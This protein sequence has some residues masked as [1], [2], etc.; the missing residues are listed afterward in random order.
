MSNTIRTAL[1]GGGSINISI[2]ADAKGDFQLEAVESWERL[3]GIQSASVS[4]AELAAASDPD[5]LLREKLAELVGKHINWKAA[6]P[7]YPDSTGEVMPWEH[8]TNWSSFGE[9]GCDEKG[10]GQF[11]KSPQYCYCYCRPIPVLNIPQAEDE[12]Q[13][14]TASRLVGKIQEGLRVVLC[15]LDW[16]PGKTCGI[17]A[18]VEGETA[19]FAALRTCNRLLSFEQLVKSED[20]GALVLEAVETL[21]N[22][23]GSPLSGR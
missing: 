5:A 11:D 20:P 23:V 14:S 19:A 2:K 10:T 7:T 3:T 13:N 16:E 22:Q 15:P 17:R 8:Q 21:A 18:T 12:P 1:L 4:A 6:E 9:T